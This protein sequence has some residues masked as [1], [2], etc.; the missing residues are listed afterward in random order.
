MEE[1]H[2][3]TCNRCEKKLEP[4][5]TGF[6]YLGQ[7]FH[8][9]VFRCPGCGQVYVPEELAKGRMAEVETALEDK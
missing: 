7:S 2:L 8:S 1:K 9:N 5:K 6:S 4:M 3:I